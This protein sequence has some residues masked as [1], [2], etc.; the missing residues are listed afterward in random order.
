MAVFSSDPLDVVGRI[1]IRTPGD[2]IE[3]S[4]DLVKPKEKRTG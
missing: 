4:L 1:A 2:S 3:R